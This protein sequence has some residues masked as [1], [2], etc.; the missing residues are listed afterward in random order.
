[1]NGNDIRLKRIEFLRLFKLRDRIIR[2]R[3]ILNSKMRQKGG[4][5]TDSLGWCHKCCEAATDWPRKYG[6]RSRL[7]RIEKASV[8]RN[9]SSATVVLSDDGKQLNRQCGN[10]ELKYGQKAA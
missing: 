3:E 2:I 9:N 4:H 7:K 8:R 10:H 5:P 1:M 6:I